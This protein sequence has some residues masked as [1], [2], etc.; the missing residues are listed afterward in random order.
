[1]PIGFITGQIHTERAARKEDLANLPTGQVTLVMTDIEG[2]TRLLDELG[3]GYAS[4]LTEVRRIHRRV[5]RSFGGHEIEARADEYF[6]CFESPAPAVEAA[7]SIQRRLAERAWPSHA[8][9]RVR[10]GVHGGRPT[11]TDAGYVGLS[12]NT[13]ARI[14][15][16]GHGG[17]VVVSR[18]TKD[19]LQAMPAGVRMRAL[20]AHRLHGLPGEHR[21]YQV[22]AKGLIADFPALRMGVGAAH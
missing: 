9:V 19:A 7:I 16:A 5:V 20:G 1:V 10:I 3:K 2:S 15:A 18:R 22:E 6:A 11:M 21:L 4:V 12:V 8:T 14:C 13:V 17:Q